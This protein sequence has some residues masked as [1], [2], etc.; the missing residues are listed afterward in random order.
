VE[1]AAKHLGPGRVDRAIA[2]DWLAIYP[3]L[4]DDVVAM[5]VIAAQFA[6]L[7][8]ATEPAARLVGDP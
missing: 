3:E 6:K 5:R 8:M 2:A 1:D 4:L 7:G